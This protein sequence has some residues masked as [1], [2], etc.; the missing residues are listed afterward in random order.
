MT[1]SIRSALCAACVLLFPVA[2]A[3]GEDVE[4]TAREAVSI[5]REAFDREDRDLRI[6]RFRRAERLFA[7]VASQGDATA[8]LY[9][10]LGNAALQAERLGHAVLAFRRA[11]L[12]D[13]DHERAAPNLEHVRSLAPDWVPR[14]VESAFFDSFFDWQRTVSSGERAFAAAVAFLLATLLFAVGLVS[15]SV[16]ARN[17]ALLPGLVWIALLGSIGLDPASGARRQAVVVGRE[18]IARSADSIHAP[19][20]FARPLPIG[21]EVELVEVREK[22]LR[23][24]LAN[25]REGWVRASAVVPVLP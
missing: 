18:V 19:Q 2:P 9:A 4:A 25:G 3:V 16:A 14:P 21:T 15:R 12:L 5:Y 6:E 7:R 22:W 20:R 8:D 13:P 23:I 17:A 11:L 1:R 24:A 10:N